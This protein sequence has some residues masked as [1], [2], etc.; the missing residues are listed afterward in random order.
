MEYNM[1]KSNPNFYHTLHEEVDLGYNDKEQEE[2]EKENK[3]DQLRRKLITPHAS[4]L[5]LETCIGH[6]MNR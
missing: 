6:N 5:V 2:A 1:L 3:I 4:G